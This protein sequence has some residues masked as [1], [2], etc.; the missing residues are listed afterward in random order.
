MKPE[1]DLKLGIRPLIDRRFLSRNAKAIAGYCKG[2]RRRK[3]LFRVGLPMF[4][5]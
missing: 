2:L 1:F 5:Q 3:T 4:L